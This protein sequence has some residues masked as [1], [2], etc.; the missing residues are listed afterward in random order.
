MQGSFIRVD[1]PHPPLYPPRHPRFPAHS[2]RMPLVVHPHFHP[3]RT[4]V[5]RHVESVVPPLSEEMETRVIGRALDPA[6]PSIEWGEL[7]RRARREP[8][9][10][11]AHRN[12]EL[13]AGLVLRSLGAR[14]R[15]VFTRHSW[16]R[17]GWFTRLL[18]RGADRVVALTPQ[19][20][21]LLPV[22]ATVVGHGLDTRRFHPPDDRDA[23]WSALGVGGRHG[24]AFIGR[25]R[26][27]KGAL[28]FAEAVAPLL[29]QHP[30]WRAVFVGRADPDVRKRI[31]RM[32]PGVVFVGEVP[33][34]ERW[35]Q[36]ATIVVQPSWVESYALVR[37]EAMA[38]GC[39]LVAS[40]LPQ[41]PDFVE[42]GRTGLLFEARDVA[43]LRAAL[44]VALADPDRAREMGRRAE[45]EVRSR[46]GVENEARALAAIYRE[47][48][49]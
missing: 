13:V 7:W 25:V 6:L 11:H 28:D 26:E 32:A 21:R 35:Y 12:N 39:C 15:L 22:S 27:D 9:V 34:V 2:E 3:R 4:G 42:H 48:T 19:M 41:L 43:G 23:A 8:V 44:A 10:W 47:L 31:E 36:G 20:T 30:D 17:P 29:T 1:L 45:E 16:H 14:I 49:G 33:D 24:V 40:R 18:M 37:L 5:T 46:F 38:S